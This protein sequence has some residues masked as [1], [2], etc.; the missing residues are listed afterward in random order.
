MNLSLCTFV[1]C[2]YPFIWNYTAREESFCA[3]DE[4]WS[5]SGDGHANLPWLHNIYLFVMDDDE[6]HY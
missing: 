2:L 1:S 6:D 3:V 5:F 4:I